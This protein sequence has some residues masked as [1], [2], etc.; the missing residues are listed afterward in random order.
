[1]A[2]CEI[3][4]YAHT[5]G[6]KSGHI[7]PAGFHDSNVTVTNKTYNSATD[8]VLQST[9][10]F[11]RLKSDAVVFFA[12]DGTAT[13]NSTSLEAETPEFFGVPKG[14]TISLYDGVS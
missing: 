5:A 4:E 2:T 7:I 6:D 12:V 11:V 10:M 9:T 14:A 3:T 8:H 13:A 1:M